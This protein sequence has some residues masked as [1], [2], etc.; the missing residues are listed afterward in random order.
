[1]RALVWPLFA[2][3]AWAQPATVVA[4]TIGEGPALASVRLVGVGS[5]SQCGGGNY[6]C[7][8]RQPLW[9]GS[10]QVRALLWPLIASSAWVQPATVVVG[11]TGEGAS[12]AS[13]RFV[14]VGSSR[15]C[16]DWNDR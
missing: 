12:L 10:R 9:R 1:V 15:Q 11:M 3:S 6:K 7:K 14:G 4:G 13:V 8:L 16:G 2:R 5:A